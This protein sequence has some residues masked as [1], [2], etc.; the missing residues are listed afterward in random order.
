MRKGGARNL[1]THEKP[2]MD[3]QE[4]PLYSANRLAKLAGVAA[5]TIRNWTMRPDRALASVE[6]PSGHRMYRVSDLH[7]FIAQN[8]ELGTAAEAGRRVAGGH[9]VIVRESDAGTPG[10]RRTEAASPAEETETL[11]AALRDLRTAL[12]AS[13]QAVARSAELAEQTAVAHR[14]VIAAFQ[15]TVRAYDS[16]FTISTASRTLN[17]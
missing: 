16:A 14:E 12:D 6:T 11:R 13:V 15:T 10:R 7:R 5:T 4:E 2:A 17:D 3:V 9:P 8:P 1:C